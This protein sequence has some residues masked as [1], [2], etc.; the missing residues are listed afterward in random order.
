[1]DETIKIDMH[2]HTRYS[3]DSLMSEKGI[4][5]A[6]MKRGLTGA[7]VTDHNT[8]RGALALKRSAPRDFKVIV[9]QEIETQEGEI[10]GYFLEEEIPPQLSPEE[11]VE[12]IKL[13]GG[14]VG[15]PHPFGSFRKSNIRKDALEKVIKRVDIIEVFNSRNICAKD[16]RK[17]VN[18]ARENGVAPAAGS[19]AHLD[20]EVGNAYVEIDGFTTPQQF[21]QNLRSAKLITNRSTPWVHTVTGCVKLLRKSHLLF[22][23][24]HAH[25]FCL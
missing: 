1:M 14:L 19:D 3:S 11:T 17:A 23:A 15:I 9:G 20:C 22:P 10:M 2:V 16:D 7:A 5:S 18:L 6:C 21:L 4:I 13:Q 24:G 25:C 8:I 12:R